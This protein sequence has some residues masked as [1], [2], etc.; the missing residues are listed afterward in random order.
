MKKLFAILGFLFALFLITNNLEADAYQIQA[1][2]KTKRIPAGTKLELEMANSVLSE[3]LSQGDMFSAYLTRDVRTVSTMILPRGT[4]VRGNVS[5]V[6]ESK[7]PYR[8]AVLY[9]NFDHVVAPN[10]QQLP[11][12]AGLC[13][14]FNLTDNG[15]IKGG[16]N[17]GT[18]VKKNWSKSGAIIKKST[19]WGITS[20]EDL[21]KGGKYLVTP[22]AAIGGTIAGAGYFVGVSVADLFKK[23]EDVYI[24]K[25][26]VFNILMLEAL[27]V[28]VSE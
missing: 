10:G 22:F 2:I 3:S 26:Q 24:Q 14:D 20:G 11:I 15:G 4:I 12:K 27:D 16:G 5:K 1:D 23:G 17:Y 28:P 21:F 6:T 18:K 7:R 19:K 13:E 25:G 9:L 8:S